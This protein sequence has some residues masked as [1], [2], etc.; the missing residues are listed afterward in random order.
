M[1]TGL[2]L[3]WLG[4]AVLLMSVGV[5]LFV[6]GVLNGPNWGTVL[7]GLIPIGFAGL[8]LIG[9]NGLKRGMTFPPNKSARPAIQ[10]G[11]GDADRGA[12]SDL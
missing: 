5:P 8:W 7:V 10:N 2:R 3:R 9:F 1:I 12:G 4:I 11:E 6:S